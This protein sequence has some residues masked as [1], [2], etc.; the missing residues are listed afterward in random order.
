MEQEIKEI[1]KDVRQMD[2]EKRGLNIKI[3]EMILSA[4]LYAGVVF[5]LCLVA[6]ANYA[7]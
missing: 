7:P 1:D 5:A 6:G 3:V 2:R 4:A